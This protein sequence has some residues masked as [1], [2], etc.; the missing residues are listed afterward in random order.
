MKSGGIF[1]RLPS[2]SWHTFDPHYIPSQSLGPTADF[3][4]LYNGQ[5]FH[6]TKGS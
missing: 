1:G 4:C 2:G 5:D 6:R 3:F